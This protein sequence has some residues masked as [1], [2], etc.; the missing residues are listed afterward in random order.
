M[1]P[2]RL[3]DYIEKKEE[4]VRSQRQKADGI[5]S[6]LSRFANMEKRSSSEIFM[7]EK[8]I[9]TAYEIL[10]SNAQEND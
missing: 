6:E 1:E 2:Y 3:Y 7:G 8:A 4:D 9:R 5:I 10:L